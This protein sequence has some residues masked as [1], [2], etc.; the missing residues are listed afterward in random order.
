MGYRFVT[1]FKFQICLLR[2]YLENEV[3]FLCGQAFGR[4]V[5]AHRLLKVLRAA[6]AL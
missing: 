3:A 4:T 5:A 1:K 6:P 2:I